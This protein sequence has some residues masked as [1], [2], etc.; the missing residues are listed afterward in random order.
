MG[1]DRPHF[2]LLL[3][4]I[5]IVMGLIYG[6]GRLTQLRLNWPVKLVLIP[7]CLY[8]VWNLA[9]EGGSPYLYFDF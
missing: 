5:A 1:I 3:W 2:A 4:V 9:P 7:L 8:A 6:V